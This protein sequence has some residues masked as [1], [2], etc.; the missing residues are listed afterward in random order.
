F[1]LAAPVRELRAT[2]WTAWMRLTPDGERTLAPLF[3]ARLARI[4]RGEPRPACVPWALRSPEERRRWE[5]VADPTPSHM[6]APPG[7]G[8]RRTPR[9][10]HEARNSDQR[11]PA[12]RVPHR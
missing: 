9:K 4:F 11:C 12:R 10:S 6:P 5:S 7:A 1:T 8:R 3:C 2:R